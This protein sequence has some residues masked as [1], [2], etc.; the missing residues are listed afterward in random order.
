MTV[1]IVI[2]NYNVEVFLEQC[3]EAVRSAVHDFEAEIF[4][5][6]NASE[7]N[8]AERLAELYPEVVFISN[9]VNSGFAA[10]NNLA[11]PMCT[12]RYVLLLNPDTVIG[13]NSLLNLCIFMDAHLEAGAVGVKMIN[14]WGRFL[15]ESKR[16]FP[17]PWASFCK[18][19]GLSKLFPK[20]PRMAGYN[21]SYLPMGN[22]H[23][24]DVLAG[25]F[26]F[27]RRS[28]LDRVGLLDEA[29]FMY[30]EDIDL[31][32]RIR[33]AG[34]INYYLPMRIL[35]YKGESSRQMDTKYIRSF[36]GAMLIFFRKY[37]QGSSG[38]TAILIRI[39]VG[40]KIFEAYLGKILCKLIKPRRITR[41]RLAIVGLENNSEAAKELCLRQIP[42]VSTVTYGEDERLKATDIAFIFPDLSF[43]EILRFMDNISVQSG[44]KIRF[45]I[46]HISKGTV[47][48]P[49]K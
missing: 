24:V 19:F 47:V 20:S 14:G 22:T 49:T 13:E 34:Y 4:V 44:G 3:L 26:M 1:S 42:G 48:S 10:A 40:L 31:S 21:L 16:G 25:A 8:P 23:A 35:H 2:V 11:L 30:G 37:Y 17:T 38:L 33:R 39:A 36:Y 43:D 28:A 9:A 5:V 45:H 12:G 27:I 41:R 18:L 7:V 32:W 29:F 15:P 6:D 46:C